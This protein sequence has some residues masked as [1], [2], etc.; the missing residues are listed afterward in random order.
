MRGEFKGVFCALEMRCFEPFL[1]T[2]A[3]TTHNR[4]ALLE[5]ALAGAMAQTYT[6]L[7][8]IV[9]DNA[10]TDGTPE[11]MA[12]VRDPRVRYVRLEEPTSMAGNFQNALD[13]ARGELF[14][15]LNDDDEL[16]PEAIE[17]L[18]DC[19]WNPPQK[20]QPSQIVLSWCPCKIQS[21]NRGVRYVSDGGPRVESG[22]DMVAALFDGRR[23]PHLCGILV[24]T[25]KALESGYRAKYGALSDLGNWMRIVVRGGFVCCIPKAVA[26][27]TVHHKSYTASSAPKGWQEAGDVIVRDLI[28][29]LRQVGNAKGIQRIRNGRRNFIT[30]LLA[31]IL[32]QSM[33][34]PGWKLRAMREILRAPQYFITPMTLRR[35]L[36]ESGKLFKKDRLVVTP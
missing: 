30:G 26:R 13:H 7:E 17:E 8:I 33:G 18:A 31:A 19:F 36:F 6:K 28:E 15:I 3:I 35:L 34:T 10:S 12:R 16:E 20:Y 23:G 25:E 32:I 9:S 2:I 5:R 1:V 21:E 14:M 24:R 22:V 4:R 27:Y 29:D 11:L